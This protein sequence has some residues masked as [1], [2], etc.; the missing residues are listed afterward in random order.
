M[1]QGV[2]RGQIEADAVLFKMLGTVLHPR[3]A[4]AHRDLP[5][6]AGPDRTRD[7][8]GLLALA[9]GRNASRLAHA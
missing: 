7:H 3:L 1:R 5:V 2:S 8:E 9:A 4:E 6:V